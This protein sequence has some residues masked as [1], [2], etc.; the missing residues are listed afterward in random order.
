MGEIK[1]GL[2]AAFAVTVGHPKLGDKEP[3]RS[4]QG[5]EQ[6]TA[7]ML[8]RRAPYGDELASVRRWQILYRCGQGEKVRKVEGYGGCTE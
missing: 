1:G 5:K 4:V 2:L 6:S 3:L 7:A 8:S